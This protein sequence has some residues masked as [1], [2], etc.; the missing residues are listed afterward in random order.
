MGGNIVSQRVN[1]TQAEMLSD[2]ATIARRLLALPDRV[3]SVGAMLMRHIVWRMRDKY[4]DGSATAAVLARAVARDAHRLIVAGADPM[5]LRRGIERGAQAASAALGKLSQ[6]LEGAESIAGLATA[7]ITE[8]EIGRLL[9]EMYDFLG[10]YGTIVL[11]PALGV[12]HDH[13]Y[14]A[15]TR[16]PGEYISPYLLSDPIRHVAALDDTYVLVAEMHFETAESVLP[17]VAK[18]AEAGG[19]NLFIICKN[20]WTKAIGALVHVNTRSAVKVYAARIRPVENL[21]PEMMEDFALLTGATLITDAAGMRAENITLKDLGHAQ[22][23]VATGDYVMVLSGGDNTE[24]VSAHAQTLHEQLRTTSKL[25]QK[26][27]LRERIGR[28][29]GGIGELRL[30][31]FTEQERVRLIEKTAHAIKVIQVGL[32]GGVVPG[33]GAAYLAVIPAVEAVEAQ[34]DEA[35]GVRVVARALEE[36]LRVIAGNGHVSAP[37]ILAECRRL[38]IGYGFDVHQHRVTDMRAERILDPA[39][40]VREALNCAASGAMML[41]TAETLVLHRKPPQSINP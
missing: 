11:Q 35:M 39:I 30:A 23:V 40:I 1:S 10:S 13:A 20:M 31:A 25:E 36:P 26:Q 32:E 27:L 24:A 38:G 6:S 21:R 17:I 9:G 7:A 29:T 5:A 8:P 41:I 16:F 12:K 3:E 22:R 28:L 33:G 2:G 19:G 4:G 15:G 14:H 34:G 18:V 37:L